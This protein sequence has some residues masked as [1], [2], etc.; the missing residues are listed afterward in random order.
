MLSRR[1]FLIVAGAGAGALAAPG[2][3]GMLFGSRGVEVGEKR[4]ESLWTSESSP[5]ASAARF[6][7]ER[8]VDLAIIG[9]GYTGLSCAYYAKRFRP[10]WSI[11]VL[12]S[13]RL[14]SGASSRNSGAVYAKYW[15]IDNKE[16][17]QRGLERLVRFIEEEEIECDFK[18]TPTIQVYTSKGSAEKAR[19]SLEPGAKWIPAEEFGENAHTDYYAGAAEL[20]GYYMVHT[21]KL[22]AGHVK[23]AGRAGVELYEDSP[24]LEVKGGKPA[25]IVMSGGKIWADNVLIATNAYTPRL[26]FL[27]RV[28]IPVHQ[29]TF[30]TRRLTQEEINGF[31]LER[32]PLRFEKNTLPVTSFITR[33]GHFCIRI[34]IGYASFNSCRWRD[35]DGARRLAKKMFEQRFPWVADV[36][37]EHGWHGVTGHT[38]KMHEIVSPVV[39]D[40]IHVS[41]AFNGRG[42]MPGHN[43]GYL[44]ACRITGHSDED[45]RFLAGTSGHIPIPGEF[46][47]S[48]MLKPF[49]RIMTPD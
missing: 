4:E 17:P 34:V 24:A 37:L 29:Y 1:K 5:V 23:A 2:A 44:S 26:G 48:I 38:L 9:G 11:V 43:S 16:M 8:K 7:G 31:G 42:I 19:A 49:M 46:Y 36:E 25:E 10:E 13:H 14:G 40:N 12:E 41:A 27:E 15:G 47:R 32:W 33:S 39:G 3:G 45:L 18:P 6:T 21:A 22:V 35:I 30:A 20:P 28:M